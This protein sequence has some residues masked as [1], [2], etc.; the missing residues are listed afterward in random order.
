MCF[1]QQFVVPL[2]NFFCGNELF[3]QELIS[4]RLTFSP[5]QASAMNTAVFPAQ[6]GHQ[7]QHRFESFAF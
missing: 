6:S 5:A 4:R 2:V 7:A 1:L 3:F